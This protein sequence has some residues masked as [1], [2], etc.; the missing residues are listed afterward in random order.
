MTV[1]LPAG[2]VVVEGSDIETGCTRGR[3]DGRRIDASLDEEARGVVKQ[4]LSGHTACQQQVT[5]RQV[6]GRAQVRL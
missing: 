5:H 1:G 4:L 3:Q 2:A 6:H